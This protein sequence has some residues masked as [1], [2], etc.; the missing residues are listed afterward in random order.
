MVDK[1]LKNKVKLPIVATQSFSILRRIASQDKINVTGWNLSFPPY[2][3]IASAVCQK[4]VEIILRKLK[5]IAKLR[6]WPCNAPVVAGN[7]LS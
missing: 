2:N 1:I 6:F 3:D 4:N 7:N 5:K